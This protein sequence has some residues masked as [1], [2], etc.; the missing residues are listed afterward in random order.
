MVDKSTSPHSR[1]IVSNLD[2]IQG[3]RGNR[4]TA[5]KDN[6]AFWKRVLSAYE[7][8][9]KRNFIEME[10]RHQDV[11]MTRIKS[12]PILRK[13]EIT[14]DGSQVGMALEKDDWKL[15]PRRCKSGKI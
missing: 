4:A 14:K 5:I 2:D 7:N 15:F 3:F 12:A 1:H 9:A 6:H 11:R 8:E 10:K 13:K